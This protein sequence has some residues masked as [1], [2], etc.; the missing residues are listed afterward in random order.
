MLALATLMAL[1][2]EFRIPSSAEPI[3]LKKMKEPVLSYKFSLV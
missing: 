3:Y 1:P 2:F